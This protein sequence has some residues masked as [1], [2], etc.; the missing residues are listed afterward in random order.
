MLPLELQRNVF[1]SMSF[2]L[3]IKLEEKI[4]IRM[5]CSK[6][7]KALRMLFLLRHVALFLGRDAHKVTKMAGQH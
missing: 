6:A 7:V 5:T 2:K 4:I 3:S 1:K